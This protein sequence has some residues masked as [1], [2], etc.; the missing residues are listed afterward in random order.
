MNRSATVAPNRPKTTVA[1]ITGCLSQCRNTN[2]ITQRIAAG[3]S[4]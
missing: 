4:C 1:V 3:L 2:G